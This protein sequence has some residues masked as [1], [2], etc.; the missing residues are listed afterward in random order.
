MIAAENIAFVLFRPQS[1]GNVGAAA[2]ALKN[3]GF[4]DLRLVGAEIPD[5]REASVMAVHGADLFRRAKNYPDLTTALYDRTLTLGTTCRSGPYRSDART[6]RQAALELS[7]LAHTNRVAIIFGPEDHGLT[8]RELRFCQRLITIPTAAEY[9]S[10]NLSQ[11]VML[12]AYELMIAMG[13]VGPGA[14]A[15]ELAAAG[16]VDAMFARMTRALLAIGF[17][18]ADNP[19]HI[20]FAL[21]AMFGRSGLKPREVDILNGLARQIHWFA[22]GG[23]RT[24]EAKRLSGRKLR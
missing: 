10:L 21:R 9:P 16:A 4:A 3:M 13:R 19:E 6:L 22:Q 20:M 14:G 7:A 24:L 17:L 18:P 11:A 8:N 23:H 15:A 1:P 2:R 5:S 12:V